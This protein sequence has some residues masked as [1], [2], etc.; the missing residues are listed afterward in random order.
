MTNILINGNPLTDMGVVMLAG[1]YAELMKPAQVK[2]YIENDDPNKHGVEVDATN[3]PKLK[4]RELT[5]KFLIQGDSKAQFLQR[6][7]AFENM[8]Y[9]GAVTL[10][11][12]DMEEYFHL[13]YVTVTQY[14]NYRLNACNMAVK[15]KEPDPTNRS[16]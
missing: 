3:P 6:K 16:A 1:S 10:Y 12:P 9:Q 15:F 13:L 11:V 2:N 8:L 4:Q 7:A 14:G 5:L